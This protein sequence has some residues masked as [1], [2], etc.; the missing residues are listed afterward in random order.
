[1]KNECMAKSHVNTLAEVTQSHRNR[2]QETE[3]SQG[4]QPLN[5]HLQRKQHGRMNSYYSEE[6][7]LL[8]EKLFC[9]VSE[10]YTAHVLVRELVGLTR[11]LD[12]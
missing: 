1:M 9:W 7:V 4:V 2:Y 3:E 6:K 5:C 12:R 8:C 10:T 11:W